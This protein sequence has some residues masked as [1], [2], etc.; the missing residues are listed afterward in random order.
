MVDC[1]WTSP[2]GIQ[3]GSTVP[4][5]VPDWQTSLSVHTSPS[6]QEFPSF[7]AVKVSQLPSALSGS[8]LASLH[9]SPAREQSGAAPPVHEPAWQVSPT[10]HELESSQEAPWFAGVWTQLSLPKSH[11]P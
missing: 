6:L 2:P 1:P 5:H 9:W 11:T 4:S 7:A 3:S 8:Q 10:L